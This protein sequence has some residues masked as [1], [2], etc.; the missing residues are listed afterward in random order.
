MRANDDNAIVYLKFCHGFFD[1]FGLREKFHRP[2]DLTQPICNFVGDGSAT[3]RTESGF[4]E[5]P[6]NEQMGSLSLSLNSW[7]GEALSNDLNISIAHGLDM[8]E[9]A[10]AS[11]TP[12]CFDTGAVFLNH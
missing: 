11:R 10:I 2:D 8:R 6:R 3:R 4:R 12:A 9:R 1:E 7:I 5:F